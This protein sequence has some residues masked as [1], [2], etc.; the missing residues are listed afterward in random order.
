MKQAIILLDVDGRTERLRALQDAS[1][2]VYGI[3]PHDR[4]CEGFTPI[5]VPPEWLPT[6]PAMDYARKCW[7]ATG[8]LGL[9]AILHLRLHA[10]AYW[11]IESDCVATQARWA[12]ML[13]DHADNETDG[14]FICPRTRAET[15]WNHRWNDPTTPAWATHTHLNAIYRLSA[16][17]VDHLLAAAEECRECFGEMVV[18]SVIHR[19]GGTLGRINRT[20]IHLNAQTMKADPAKVIFN[21][22]L[23]NH[24]DKRNTYGPD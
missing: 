10:D 6:D 1:D 18:A 9:A 23:V 20:G 13:E 15:A 14:S 17:A 7:H 19:A 21:R 5:T 16:R 8:T 2:S 22:R 24:P 4:P 11:L 12:A 3:T